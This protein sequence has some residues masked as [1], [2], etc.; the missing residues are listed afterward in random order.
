MGTI[1]VRLEEDIRIRWQRL[2]EAHGLVPENEMRDAIIERLEE[3]EDYY[4]VQ[5]RLIRPY[6]PVSNEE[7]WRRLD[8]GRALGTDQT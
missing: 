2:A 7:V 6:D 8:A 4:V 1:G 3:L 5:S